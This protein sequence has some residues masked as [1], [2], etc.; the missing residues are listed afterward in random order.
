[1]PML[2]FLAAILAG[3]AQASTASEVSDLSGLFQ[4][5]CLDGQ[6]RLRAN[7]VTP[8]SFDQLP[9]GLR[10]TLGRPASGKVWALNASGH[11]YLYL[12]D[13]QAGPGVSPKVCGLASDAM[14][15]RPAADALEMRV[16]GNVSGDRV[17]SAQWLNPEHGY[18]ATVTT[19]SAFN[20][21]QISWMSDADR[22]AALVQVQALAH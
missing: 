22:A 9:S 21:L 8:I 5:T 11:S 14:E 4:A 3:S 6:A 17:H 2:L 18:V 10:E 19:A 15:L 20:V 7:E 12:L 1:M 16:T 13:Y